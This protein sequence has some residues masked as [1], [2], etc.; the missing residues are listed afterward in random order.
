MGKTGLDPSRTDDLCRAVRA[1]LKDCA[2]P[3][4]VIGLQLGK[5]R[6]VHALGDAHPVP[7]DAR[8]FRIASLTKPITGVAALTL[9]EDG[10]IALE[11]P[12]DRWLPELN[13]CRVL[14]RPD[15]PLGQTEPASRSI[16][17]HDLLTCRMGTGLLVGAEE[18]PIAQAMAEAHVNVGATHPRQMDSDTWIAALGQL[19]LIHQP[20]TVWMYDTSIEVL[21]VL[22]ERASGLSLAGLFAER[23]FGPLRMEDTGFWVP[24][25]KLWRLGPC[26][27]RG[28]A[29]ECTILDPAGSESDLRHPPGF[30][31]AAEGLVSSP[32]DYMTF[33]SMMLNRGRHGSQR[34]LS[35]ATYA[36]MT[37]DHIAEEQKF[38]S[39]FWPGFWSTHGWGYCVAIQ[40]GSKADDPKGIGWIG[41]LGTAC[42]WDHETGL[43]SL[44]MTQ[45][46]FDESSFALLRTFW[47]ESRRLVS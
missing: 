12:I 7:P 13:E 31:S 44:L 27:G 47:R 8:I 5:D 16:T 4:A 22:M 41:G 26:Y 35:E 34:L 42:T 32:A 33:A 3:S 21:G 30:E 39:R 25:T 28:E 1:A 43:I 20:G 11:D 24:E 23:V 18:T 19:P 9:I 37:R 6:I 46:R 40:H 45:Q 2:D 29:G 17:V 10:T 15:A 38:V 14:T 36:E